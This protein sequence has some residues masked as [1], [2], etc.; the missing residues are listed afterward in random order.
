MSTAQ[1]KRW[2]FTINNPTPDDIFWGDAA[3][4]SDVFSDFI[5]YLILQEERGENGTLHYQ[6]FLILKDKK[7][8]TWL[9]SHINERAHWEIARGNNQQAHDYCRKDD[10]YTGGLRVEMGEMPARASKS[11]SERL[12]RAADELD[13][14]KRAYK[15]PREVDS[16]VLL[17][18]GFIAAYKEL[19]SDILG[20]YRP[21][22]RVVTLVGPP[23]TGKSFAIHDLFPDAGR[24]SYGNC[25]CWF[26]NALAKV[27]VFEEFCGQ[28]Q[29]QKMLEFLDPYPKSLEVKGGYRPAMY[30]LVIITSNTP[31][32]GWYELKDDAFYD[33]RKAALQALWDRL[34]YTY[35]G[36][37][38]PQRHT[39]TYLEAQPG[40]NLDE[41]RRWFHD[42]LAKFSL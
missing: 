18:P 15:R 24:C 22:L 13:E 28:I 23:G 41:L 8:L 31:P 27:M 25:G 34:G 30:E 33:K 3:H 5:E 16:V 19:T 20:P 38:Q 35:G 4:P 40:M 36:Q 1:G 37:Y 14:V 2:C 42:N 32:S 12:E 29:L 9:K 7:R 39:G 6:G 10:T 26:S 17:Q 11:S 21:N